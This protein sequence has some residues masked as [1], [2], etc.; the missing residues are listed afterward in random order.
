VRYEQRD[1]WVIRLAAGVLIAHDYGEDRVVYIRY[2][3]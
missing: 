3:L 2:V 1:K